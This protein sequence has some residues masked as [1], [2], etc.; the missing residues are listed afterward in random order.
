MEATG[1][2]NVFEKNALKLRSMVVYRT[3]CDIVPF[4]QRGDTRSRWGVRTLEK[5]LVEGLSQWFLIPFTKLEGK[6]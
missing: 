5:E 2:A 4:N 6:R 1:R 3:A